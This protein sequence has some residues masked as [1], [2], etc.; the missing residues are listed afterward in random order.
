MYRCIRAA[1][2]PFWF[3]DNATSSCSGNCWKLH[4]NGDLSKKSTHFILYKYLVCC[5]FWRQIA[6]FRPVR[7]RD[8][9]KTA[10][11]KTCCHIC[12]LVNTTSLNHKCSTKVS[13]L[14]WTTAEVDPAVRGGDNTATGAR[15]S[16]PRK[17]SPKKRTLTPAT[18]RLP[19]DGR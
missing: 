6:T 7:V 3:A 18:V 9:E 13:R 19:R 15:S 4:I 11:G 5:S 2:P 16:P 1:L 8:S 12:H 14:S 10:Q 17:V